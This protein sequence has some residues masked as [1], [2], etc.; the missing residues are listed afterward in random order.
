M[1]VDM[2]HR[3]ALWSDGTRIGAEYTLCRPIRTLLACEET[4]EGEVLAHAFWSCCVQVAN[5]LD[6]AT[7]HEIT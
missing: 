2:N 7:D 6:N 3:G 5:D 1:A 4:R